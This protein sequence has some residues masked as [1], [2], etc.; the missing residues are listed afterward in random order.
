[1]SS[2]ADP[3]KKA[4]K[5]DKSDHDFNETLNFFYGSYGDAKYTKKV[6][7]FMKI[8]KKLLN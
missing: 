8:P 4:V 6:L 7:F 3:V 2:W 1:M 5:T